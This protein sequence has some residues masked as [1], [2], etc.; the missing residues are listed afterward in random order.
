M[1]L[2]ARYPV[3]DSKRSNRSHESE[4]IQPLLDLFPLEDVGLE[5]S[6]HR[7]I[8]H[9]IEHCAST[10]EN[11]SPESSVTCTSITNNQACEMVSS[12]PL[13][14]VPVEKQTKEKNKKEPP[15]VDWDSLRKTYSGKRERNDENMDGIDWQSV[16]Q[17][18][19]D[20]IADTIKGRGMQNVL[21]RKIKVL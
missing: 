5:R 18:T 10:S 7:G 4:C 14:R 8:S 9:E 21:A 3:R 1:S 15:N 17:A 20:D 13:K 12:L 11:G 19:T 6:V 2:A 16:R